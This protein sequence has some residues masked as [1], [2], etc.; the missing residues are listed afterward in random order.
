MT[1]ADDAE[2]EPT[3]FTM[4]AGDMELLKRVTRSLTLILVGKRLRDDLAMPA[5]ELLN[6][7]C[8]VASRGGGPDERP[9]DGLPFLEVC[10][11]LRSSVIEAYGE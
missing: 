8:G 1:Q 5:I 10:K 7:S 9:S 4:I 3:L 6:W 11:A 2:T